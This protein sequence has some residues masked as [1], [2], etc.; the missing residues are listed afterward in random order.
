MGQKVSKHEIPKSTRDKETYDN[1]RDIYNNDANA[2]SHENQLQKEK[3][4]ASTHPNSTRE[5][6]NHKEEKEQTETNLEKKLVINTNQKVNL[7]L[8]TT[9]NTNSNTVSSHNKEKISEKAEDSHNSKQQSSTTVTTITKSLNEGMHSDMEKEKNT[10]LNSAHSKKHKKIVLK[11]TGGSLNKDIRQYYKFKEVLGGGHFGTVR[12]GYKRDDDSKQF[13][14]IKSISKKNLSKKDFEDLN[15]EVEIL[16]LLD[17]P[18]II[19]FYETYNDQYYFHI[20][21]ELCK[22]KEVFDKII[23]EGHITEQKV[24][25][26]IYKVLSAISYCHSNGITHRDL[27]PENI[28]FEN[29]DG[30]AEIKLI[31]FGLSRKY[32]SKEKMHT[33]LGTPYYVAPEVLKG[34]YDE[35]CDIWSIGALTYIM[36]SGD[37]PFNGNSNNEIFDKI[38]NSELTFQKDRWKNISKEAKD[39]VKKCMV[40]IPEGRFCAIKAIEHPWFQSILAQVHSSLNLSSDILENLRNFSSPQKLKKLVLKFLVNTL[41]DKEIKKLRKAFYAIDLDHTGLISK[42]ELKKAFDVAGLKISEE[43]LQKIIETANDGENGRMDYSEFL[44]ASLNQKTFID[45]EKLVSAFRY[46]DVDDSGYIC[47]SD[48]KNA[49]LRSGKQIINTEEIDK[50]IEEV[51]QNNQKISINEFLKLFGYDN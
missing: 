22:G 51:N 38:M 32:D 36:L 26:Y 39:F 23:E 35:K 11:A 13:Y 44:I 28:L 7:N 10:Q 24:A 41:N 3:I 4:S 40:K 43:E 27:K 45:K 16:S 48:I 25:K 19:K 29:S 37:P 8:N 47:S 5:K 9:V 34:D 30:D 17:H 31:D 33:I 21:M 2:N 15:K 46:F 20:V 49:M 1:Q 42:D 18:N 6:N 12:I 50:I 14:A